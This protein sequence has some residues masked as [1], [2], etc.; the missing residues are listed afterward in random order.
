MDAI[1]A[2]MKSTRNVLLFR[3]VSRVVIRII[4]SIIVGFLVPLGTLAL[5]CYCI[6]KHRFVPVN[7]IM[8]TQSK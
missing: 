6:D 4:I 8:Q 5:P 3:R 2:H 7:R 1:Y